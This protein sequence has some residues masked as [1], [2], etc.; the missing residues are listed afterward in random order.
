MQDMERAIMLLAGLVPAACAKRNVPM[1][2]LTTLKLGGPADLV[3]E[4]E[5]EIQTAKILKAAACEH[6]PVLP[7]GR[8]SNL[9]VKDG[10]IRGCVLSMRRLRDIR[11][12][13]M[14]IHAG[15]GA[16][17]STLSAAA[18]AAGLAGLAFASGI[19][20]SVGG[21][22]KMNAGAYGGEMSQCIRMVR[23]FTMKGEP[24]EL[25]GAEM[26]FEHRYSVLM[27]DDRIV[28]E[29][30]FEL[31]PGDPAVIQAEMAELNA[32]RREKQPLE[33]PSAGSTFKRPAGGYASA[34]VD[35]CGLKG[36]Q[37]GGAAVSE[38]HAGFC[39]NL[40][41]TSSDFLQL[42]ADVQARVMERFGVMLEPEV[43]IVGEDP[44]RG[45]D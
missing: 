8:G 14:M 42:M 27:D 18:A 36:Y 33:L 37:V 4:P 35:A 17:L 31:Q 23:G 28:T 40:G 41:G 26:H 39:V 44:G 43:Q 6:V 3:L 22:V 16:N 9:L 5:N 11:V 21:A 19:P 1:A 7:V 2:A 29:A 34:M 15:A 25:T 38:K 30:V 24:F 20:G 10:G 45:N 32:R 13:G 12:D